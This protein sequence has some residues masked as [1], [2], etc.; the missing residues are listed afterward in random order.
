M[1][2]LIKRGIDVV[3]A[4][5]GLLVLS[6]VMLGVALLVRWRLGQPVLFRQLRPGLRGRPF[7]LYKFRT[8]RD[9]A[10]AQGQPLPDHMRMTPLGRWLRATSLDELPGLFN[11]L[12]GDMS[13]VGPRPLLMEYLPRYTPQQARRHEVR[14]GLTGW[15]QVNG[16]NA[17]SW[18]EKFDLDVWYV[19]HWTLRLDLAILWR[20]VG[21]VLRREGVSAAGE[22]TMPAFQGTRTEPGA[23]GEAPL[24]PRRDLRP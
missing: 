11:V 5:A 22:A 7:P 3:G 20:T 10:D 13:L 9:A 24:S 8:L 6:P 12:R 15:A 4:A 16:R 1:K 21:K 18:E 2:A 19:D 23:Q 14:P 17:I